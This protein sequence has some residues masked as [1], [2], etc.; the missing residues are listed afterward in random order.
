MLGIPARNVTRSNHD[1]TFTHTCHKIGCYCSIHRNPRCK[2]TR[3]QK[4]CAARPVLN[5]LTNSAAGAASQKIPT[6]PMLT[7][8]IPVTPPLTGIPEV[9]CQRRALQNPRCKCL[10]KS[11]SACGPPELRSLI[12]C[13]RTAC[14]ITTQPPHQV[15]CC[16]GPSKNP[17]VTHAI[18]SNHGLEDTQS[19]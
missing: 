1:H 11:A 5:S 2:C 13:A 6:S 18:K 19:G 16:Y 3:R 10:M 12:A 14:R 9:G 7:S 17:K 8:R 15:G 4:S